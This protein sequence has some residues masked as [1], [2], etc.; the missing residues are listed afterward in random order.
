MLRNPQIAMM[1]AGL[2]NM[3]QT[4]YTI[5]PGAY[6]ASKSKGFSSGGY[7]TDANSL[8]SSSLNSLLGKL[9]GMNPTGQNQNEILSALASAVSDLKK[10]ESFHFYRSL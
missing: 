3:R 8:S 9:S 4:R 7:T 1:V 5:T 10:L 6:Q 2:E